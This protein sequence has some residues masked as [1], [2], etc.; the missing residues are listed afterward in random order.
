MV[1]WSIVWVI[2]RAIHLLV[3]LTVHW[4]MWWCGDW[5]INGLSDWSS[6]PLTRLLNCSLIYPSMQLI[7]HSFVCSSIDPQNDHSIHGS[8][9]NPIPALPLSSCAANPPLPAKPRGGIIFPNHTSFLRGS[10]P[11]PLTGSSPA[12]ARS[13]GQTYQ[14]TQDQ[15]P[16]S[17]WRR[18]RDGE[19]AAHQ[20]CT[21]N[22]FAKY[23]EMLAFY[24]I[25]ENN[26]HH[27]LLNLFLKPF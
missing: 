17:T 10:N 22:G 1:D 16:Q 5:L 2:R 18:E 11:L 6:D 12:P 7:T 15:E 24:T 20:D 13:L 26:H 19:L 3:Y 23:A 4:L 9:F 27:N 8:M 14:V 25:S 21:K